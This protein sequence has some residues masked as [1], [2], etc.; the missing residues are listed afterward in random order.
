MNKKNLVY[1][2]LSLLLTTS[3][4][5]AAEANNGKPL[6]LTVLHIN[7]HHSH[8][9]SDKMNLNLDG[10]A[11]IVNLGGMTRISEEI[12]RLRKEDK[13]T[14]VLHAG[15]AMT[16]TLYYTLFE[17]V[18]DAEIMNTI[19]FDAV[20]MGNHEFDGGNSILKKY[21]TALKAPV[22]SANVTADET[23][24]LQGEWSPYIIKNIDG[25]NVGIVGLTIVGKTITSSN[26]GK[27]LK[28]EEEE[29]ATQKVVDELKS[30][31]INKIILLSHDG[32]DNNVKIARNISGVDLIVSGDTHYLLGNQFK[33]IFEYPVMGEYPTKIMSPS[34]E[35]VYVVEAASYS[36]VLGN[37][38]V[39]FNEEG[40]IT[41][42][43]GKPEIIMADNLFQ[44]KD[45]EGKTYDLQGEEKQAVL[46]YIASKD[47]IKIVPENPT[48]KEVLEKY[49]EEKLKQ[50]KEIVGKINTLI[51][52]GSDNRI[53]NKK[54]KKGSI[55]A[56]IVAKGFLYELQTMGKGNVDLFIHNAG[57]VRTSINPGNFSY[58]SGYNLLPFSNTLFVVDMTG[59]ELK[60][61]MEEALAQAIKDSSSTGA[62][63]YGAGIRY[64][65]FRTGKVGTRITKIEVKDK[66]TDH[67]RALDLT[68]TYKVGTTSYLMS[69]KDG[70]V[71]LGKIK[72][73]RGAEDTGIDDAKAFLNYV[74]YKKNITRPKTSNVNYN[75]NK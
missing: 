75:F 50:G 13:N 24:E 29:K 27:D 23:S 70:W 73:S 74:K 52:G 20:T 12:T 18:P 2:A 14:L 55:A 56:A 26:P 36:Y 53:P 68:K 33:D 59:S 17:G 49:Q 37:I 46:N 69:G 25:E 63:P 11:T 40:I 8:L 16:G 3:V 67:W 4:T 71:T 1:V 34:N 39:K 10:K 6:E 15:D 35:P 22:I 9:E 72:E 32:Y 54:N 31:G 51:P 47:F 41:E 7:D 21:L 45:T 30:K 61:V 19:N 57:S 38:K 60:Q 64:K 62:F 28:F 44:R 65:A 5:F 66:A 48:S 43:L 58:D 42:A